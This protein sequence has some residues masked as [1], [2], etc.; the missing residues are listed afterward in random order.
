MPIGQRVDLLEHAVCNDLILSWRLHVQSHRGLVA[1]MI[2][3][4]EPQMG[5]V[6]PVVREDGPLAILIL[7][8]DQT[9]ADISMV[10]HSRDNVIASPLLVRHLYFAEGSRIQR[11]REA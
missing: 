9:I 11:P 2:L 4:C 8:N 1:G 7:P 6:R 3:R 5:P 10:P